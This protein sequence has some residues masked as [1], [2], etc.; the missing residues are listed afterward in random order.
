MHGHEYII[1]YQ[2]LMLIAS[3]NFFHSLSPGSLE[4][5]EKTLVLKIASAEAVLLGAGSLQKTGCMFCAI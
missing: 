1:I 3:R 5:K 4:Q 2:H